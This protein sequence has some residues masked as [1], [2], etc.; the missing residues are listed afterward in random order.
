MRRVA[1]LAD[2]PVD[3][4]ASCPPDYAGTNRRPYKSLIPLPELLAEL[5]GTGSGSKKVAAAYGTLVE[6]AGSEFALLLD[7]NEAEIET[8]GTAGVPGEL[9]AMA[10]GRMRSGRSP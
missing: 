1:E 7:R 8:L 6:R 10:V 2:R 4:T 3:E 9:L 5:L